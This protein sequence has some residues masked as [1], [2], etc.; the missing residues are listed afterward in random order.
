MNSEKINA[1]LATGKRTYQAP[2]LVAFGQAKEMT[3][4]ANQPGPGDALF[5]ILRH[6]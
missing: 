3:R 5:S 4:N 1:A 2:D 6:S